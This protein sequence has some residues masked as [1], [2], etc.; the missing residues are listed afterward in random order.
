MLTKKDLSA[1]QNI[2]DGSIDK[3]DKKFD[4]LFNFLDKEH[5]RTKDEVREIQ[6]HLRLPISDF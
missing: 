1:I 6:K 5:M 2:V 3:I 4:K